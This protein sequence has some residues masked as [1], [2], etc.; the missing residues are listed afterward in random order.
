[1]PLLVPD[2]V[3]WGGFGDVGKRL[4]ALDGMGV[5]LKRLGRA[6]L[7][8]LVPMI[9][10]VLVASTL[11]YPT[12]EF[13]PWQPAGMIDLQVYRRT[14]AMVLAGED[15]FHVGEGLPWIYPPFAALLSVP[16]TL[17]SFSIAAICWLM[18]CVGGLG[19]VLY[20]LGFRGWALSMATTLCI[21]L[22]EPV[23][24]TIGFGQLGIILVAAA[25][26]D[27]LPGR[28]Y[29]AKRIL[30]EGWL[31]GLA[32]AVKLTPAVVAC[33]NFFAG[34]RKPG[35]IAFASFC[36]ATA[37]G[38]VLYSES[39]YYWT[40]LIGGETGVNGSFAYA[41]NQ[42][43]MGVWARLTGDFGRAGLLLSVA[44]IVIG[45][46][47]A[48]AIHK[49]GYPALGVCLAGLTSLLG[50]PVSWSHHY[51]WIVPLGIVFWQARTLPFWYRWL[52][53]AYTAWVVIAP[54]KRLPRGNDVEFDY[55]WWQQGMVN[56]GVIAGVAVLLGALAVA[57][58]SQ[59]RIAP[60]LSAGVG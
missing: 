39:L 15:F 27:S 43:V 9:A 37:L 49:A 1:M 7:L 29:F 4:E 51:V 36:A 60:P 58:S 23:R 8:G 13:W 45:V 20:R 54:F 21:V 2:V 33:Y 5:N 25:C 3:G 50:S 26:L 57:F 22:V 24:E 38:F 32:T 19:A 46:I 44:V 41:T 35:L 56:I 47:A 59:Q 52:G 12:T 34:R 11:I 40:S 18:L 10:A 16:F 42:T 48:I 6:A 28:R 55:L 30:P 17:V 53:L 31:T 14:G